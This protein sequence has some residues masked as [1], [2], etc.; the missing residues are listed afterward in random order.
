MYEFI[1]KFYQ[2]ENFF[3]FLGSIFAEIL[4]EESS[5]A[6][7][8]H[9]RRTVEFAGKPLLKKRWRKE[10]D[11]FWSLVG[12]KIIFFAQLQTSIWISWN[13]FVKSSILGA[14]LPVLENVRLHFSWLNW[15]PRGLRG[16]FYQRNNINFKEASNIFLIV[17]AAL[18]SNIAVVHKGFHN[19][20]RQ[21][22]RQNNSSCQSN[23]RHLIPT[24]MFGWVTQRTLKNIVCDLFTI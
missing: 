5:P 22:K 18:F 6:Q 4:L 16:C 17:N 2:L 8:K 9:V 13:W 24:K 10:R 11:R 7:A 23:R 12:H 15:Q 21:P 14:L 1:R 3:G 19:K 20:E